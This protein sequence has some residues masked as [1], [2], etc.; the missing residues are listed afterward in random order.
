[1]IRLPNPPKQMTAPAPPIDFLNKFNEVITFQIN[2][3]S[4][5][6]QQQTITNLST[7]VSTKN[8]EDAAEAKGW[9]NG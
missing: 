6:Q 5:L 3:A 4:A 1:M 2:L 7:S 8:A 9:F